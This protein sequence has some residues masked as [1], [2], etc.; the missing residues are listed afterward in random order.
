MVAVA[1]KG[2][3]P[4]AQI[5]KDFGISES[6][7]R[8]WLRLADV[9]DGV[10][11]GTT[12]AESAELR[13]LPSASNRLLEQENEILRRA[14]AYFAGDL[15]LPKMMY[16]LVLDLAADGIPVAVTCRVLGFSKQAFYKWRADPVVERDWDDAHLINAALDIHRDDPEFGYRFIADELAD[17][18]HAGLRA[19][20][21]GC[22]RSSGSG[23]CSPRS[24]AG[25]RSRARRCTT[26]WSSGSSPR[27]RRTGCG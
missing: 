12:A 2:E 6:C 3:A 22:A 9:E 24:A 19:G 16:P 1:R 21:T 7:L 13:E 17:A 10:R 8:S 11:P 15:L 14:A 20:C 27:R 26:T 25:P 23:R 5:A 4:I 18:A